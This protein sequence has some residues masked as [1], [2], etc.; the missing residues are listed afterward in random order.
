MPG[1]K[2]AEYR[3]LI[4]RNADGIVVV[5]AEGKLLFANPAAEKML[6]KPLE[7]LRNRPIGLPVVSGQDAADVDLLA[8]DGR[9][10]SAE[11]RVVETV[12]EGEP[13]HLV[14][15]RDVSARRE[16]EGRIRQSQKLEAIGQL[17]GGVAHDFNNL[18]T[19]I[20]SCV[21]LLRKPELAKEKRKR[22][23]DAIADTADRAAKLTGQ[24]LAFAR[25]GPLSPQL[26]DVTERVKNTAELM[27][28][29]VGSGI[30]IVTNIDCEPCLVEVDP[31]QL[32]T[33]LINMAINSR[34]AMDKKGEISIRVREIESARSFVNHSSPKGPFVEIAFTDSG[35]GI[36]EQTATRVFEPFF[37]TKDVGKGT[38]LGLSQVYGFIKQSGGDIDIESAPG[39]GT[40]I[41]LYIP[42]SDK[43]ASE[44]E[45][46]TDRPGYVPMRCDSLVLVVEDNKLVGDVAVQLLSDLG[47]RTIQAMDAEKALEAIESNNGDIDLVFSDIRMPGKYDGVGLAQEIQTRWPDLPVV[48]TSGY[49]DAMAE[50]T[51]RGFKL[52]RKPYSVEMLSQI[53]R[54]SAN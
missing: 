19:I 29:V 34:D 6:G 14:S 25:R 31:D 53:I 2:E 32:E 46:D 5:D 15:L 4:D 39:N 21:D 36:D 48:L 22:Y 20:R 8:Q 49:S 17:T 33:A 23:I 9:P 41:L 37:T 7:V 45:E 38:G 26:F 52:L 30:S 1:I 43:P 35:E 40:T 27:E 42:K 10:V 54:R 51:S 47:Y 18:L 3:F 28:T 44:V 50:A 13:A 24:L 11:M 12:W 16:L